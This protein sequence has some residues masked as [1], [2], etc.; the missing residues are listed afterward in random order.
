MVAELL[1]TSAD[2]ET[3]VLRFSVFNFGSDILGLRYS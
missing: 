3:R 1:F 2:F